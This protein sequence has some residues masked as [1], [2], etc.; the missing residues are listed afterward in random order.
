MFLSVTYSVTF[1]QLR[2]YTCICCSISSL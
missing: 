2:W 1:S